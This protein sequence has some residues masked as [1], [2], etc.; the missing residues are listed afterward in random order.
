MRPFPGAASPAPPAVPPVVH[1]A[2]I[3]DAAYAVPTAVAIR[4]LRDSRAPG[5]RLAVHVL[6]RGVP[7]A[8]LAAILSLADGRMSVEARELPPDPV[9]DGLSGGDGHVSPLAL[10]KFRLAETFPELDRLLYLD[11]DV[12]VRRDLSGLWNTDLRG[13][14]LAAAPDFKVEDRRLPQRLGFAH[15]TYF[16]SGVMLLDLVRWRQEGVGDRLAAYKLHGANFFMDQDAFNA[17]LG[18]EVAWWP[19]TANFMT[20][21]LNRA[22]LPALRKFHRDRTLTVA[23][24]AAGAAV[25]HFHAWCKPWICCNV[26]GSVRW[27]ELHGEV[28]PGRPL[29]RR[30]LSGAERRRRFPDAADAGEPLPPH[31]EIVVSL[32]SHPARI[33]F[34][35]ASVRSLLAGTVLPD[36]LEVWLARDR[37]PGGEGDLPEELRALCAEP[38]GRVAVRW[39]GEDLGPA[40]KL[41]YARRAHPDAIVATFDDDQ[42]YPAD[43]LE[44]L[45]FSYG[46]HPEAVSARRTHLMAVSEGKI[47][48]YSAWPQDV[49]GMADEPSHQLLATGVGGVLYPPRLLPERLFDAETMRRLSPRNDDL[50]FKAVELLAGVPVVQAGEIPPLREQEGCRET[51]LAEE[52]VVARG[53]D[54]Q[55]RALLDWVGRE[56]GLSEA[57]L[58]ARGGFRT[59]AT[60]A[61][62]N[63]FYRAALPGVRAA[64]RGTTAR[65]VFR[66]VRSSWSYRI[67]NF[68]IRP[69][70]WLKRRFAERGWRAGAR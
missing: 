47:L 55:L 30:M 41:L 56:S 62:L 22:Y 70:S 8:D 1:V 48:P 51:G 19:A 9:L 3:A 52:N 58:L 28:F 67:G 13:A 16:N 33:G 2:F 64:V 24:L 42:L 7:P 14:F 5:T 21:L 27:K 4:S 23:R 15:D 57:A 43:A 31:P 61:E 10:R 38:G 25:V 68:L 59:V 66:L 69:F 53:N 32:S 11:G 37:F 18:E 40:T 35:A 39:A 29:H 54:G 45:L 44:I 36:R 50:W 17:V 60:A 49:A 6:C 20:Y 26:P 65:A 34:A 12:L 63:D 46:E